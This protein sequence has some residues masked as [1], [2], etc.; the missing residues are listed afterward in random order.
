MSTKLTT[1]KGEKMTLEE[2]LKDLGLNNKEV[3]VYLALLQ[4]GKASILL[5][6]KQSNIKRS[7]VYE[8][9]GGL[10]NQ[11][12]VYIGFEDKKKIWQPQAPEKLMEILR[13]RIEHLEKI[14]PELNTLYLI[15]GNKP[16]ILYF[17]GNEGIKNAFAGLIPY[18]R[19]SEEYLIISSSQDW[20]SIDEKY[21]LEFVDVRNK[22]GV[23]ARMLC[24]KTKEN[25]YYSQFAQSK[26]LPCEITFTTNMVIYQNKIIFSSIEDKFAL[27]IESQPLVNQQKQIFE[28]LW[29]LIR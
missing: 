3:A 4:L 9:L 5:I 22:K 13:Y 10:K 15:P 12:L 7:T 1:S 27:V 17:E 29:K 20:F 11:G 25:I 6:S 18:F 26:F 14:L 19:K 24:P 2:T 23:K 16:K 21:F 8:I 28:L